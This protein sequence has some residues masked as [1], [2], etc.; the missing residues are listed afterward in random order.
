MNYK[1]L[2]LDLDGTLTNSEKEL[3]QRNKET[4][5]KAQEK[6]VT[7]ALASGR[8]MFG[9]TPLAEALHLSEFGGYILSFNGG[10]TIA[11][12]DKS[13]IQEHIMP[14]DTLPEL[15]R[16]SKEHKMELISYNDT[17]ILSENPEDIYVQKEAFLNKM[18]V[19]KIENL[20]NYID[21]NIPKCLMVGDAERLAKIEPTIRDQHKERLTIFRSEPYFLEIMP[22][23]IDKAQSLNK[24]LAHMKLTP[25]NMIAIG[26]GFND[27]SMIQL[28]GL[29]IAMAN[30]QEVVK[31]A[32]RHITLS[33]DEDGVAIAVEQ[34]LLN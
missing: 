1:L 3:S 15:Y 5:I 23:G 24:L 11:C 13:I 21:F 10:K 27:L 6:G 22:Q 19:M 14:L 7:I 32:A 20:V 8:P 26:D 12:K 34:F 18:P 25:E 30:A 17:H 31:K 16:A 9:I 33:N 4:L 29:G 28:A 2:V